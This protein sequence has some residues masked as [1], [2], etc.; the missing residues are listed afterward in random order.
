MTTLN[1]NALTTLEMA[2]SQL[3]IPTLETTMDDIITFW[4]NVASDRFESETSRKIKKQEHAEIH[5]GR[6][7][8]ILMLR[9]WPIAATPAARLFIDGGSEFNADSEIDASDFRIADNDNSIVLIGSLF[10][11]GYNNVKAIYTAGYEVVPSDIENAVLWMVSYYRSMRDAGDIGRQSKSKGG[12]STSF[13]QSLPQEIMD[14]ISK[15]KRIEAPSIWASL[16]ST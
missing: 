2:K 14:V 13:L 9:E 11:K 1:Q 3:K 16:S 6:G 7:N 4:I 5:H 8:N 15:Y 10:P 12:E